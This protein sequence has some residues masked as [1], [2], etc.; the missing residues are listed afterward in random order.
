M[1]FQSLHALQAIISEGLSDIEQI[2]RSPPHGG[3]ALE[4]PS[5]DNPSDPASPSEKLTSHPKV[6]AAIARISSAATQLSAS[7]RGPF[8]T[9]CNASTGVRFLRVFLVASFDLM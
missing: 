7:V 8:S 6:I 5:L 2:Y 4:F 9:L 1:T 3:P